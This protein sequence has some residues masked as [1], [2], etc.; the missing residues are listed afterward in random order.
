L[1]FVL[2]GLV[3]GMLF[4]AASTA[5]AAPKPA[6]ASAGERAYQKCYSCH[7]LEPGKND[8]DG[9]SL[10]RIVGRRVAVE[11]GFA[12]SPAMKRFAAR[13]PRWTP[14]LIDRI[15]ADPDAL[16][17]GTSMNFHGI[18]DANERAALIAYLRA[19]AKKR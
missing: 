3:A 4:D 16:V 14:Q 2:I 6:P 12:Y 15:A 9:P 18:A 13:N 8:L 7:A 1:N 11:R 19:A 17:P 10:H 5:R